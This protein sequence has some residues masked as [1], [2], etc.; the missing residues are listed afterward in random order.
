MQGLYHAITNQKLAVAREKRLIKYAVP[1][2][3]QY[4]GFGNRK[5]FRSSQRYLEHKEIVD[6]DLRFNFEHYVIIA[7]LNGK[8]QWS[9]LTVL[10]LD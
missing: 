7:H 6:I 1:D 10:L 4:N 3:N 8:K 2:S 5:E 9:D